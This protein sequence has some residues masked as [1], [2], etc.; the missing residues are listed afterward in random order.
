MG[1][2]KAMPLDVDDRSFGAEAL[3]ELCAKSPVYTGDRDDIEPF[4]PEKVSWPPL[5]FQ[6]VPVESLLSHDDALWFGSWERH[7]L[8]PVEDA[9]SAKD[10]PIRPYVDVLL[11][12]S[13]TLYGVFLQSM[14]GRG[15]IRFAPPSSAK[16]HVGI[17]LFGRRAAASAS[18]W[19]R[20]VATA[21]SATPRARA[22][23]PRRRSA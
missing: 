7:M 9:A 15:L 19:T 23:R 11:R 17:F 12:R 18:S 3:S 20:E 16:E 22:C 21:P 4:D 14:F 13:P 2:Y 8:R 5:D 1:R 10:V 6:P